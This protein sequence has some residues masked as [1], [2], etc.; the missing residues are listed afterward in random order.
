ME[1]IDPMK[2]EQL[3]PKLL[4]V[5][6]IIVNRNGGNKLKNCLKQISKQDYPKELLETLLVDGGSIDNSKE[7]AKQYGA[8][9]IKGGFP[10]NME[11]RRH[12][13][14]VK[15]ENEIIAFIDTDN[16]LPTHDWLRRMVEPLVNNKKIFAAETLHYQY[17]KKD[18][19][20][21]RYCALFGVNDPV[22]FYLGKADRMPHFYSSW[23]QSGEVKDR[24]SYLEIKFGEDLPTVGC[25]GFLIRR[26]ILIKSLTKPES[27]FHIDSIYD[28]VQQGFN[29][30]AFVKTTIT[31]DTSD[32][33]RNLVRKR[34]NYYSNH[35]LA[36]GGERRYRVYNPG[37]SS[38]NVRILLY[39]I[40]TLTLIKPLFD[41]M[42]GFVRKPDIAWFLH[43]IVCF[44]FLYAYGRVVINL[45]IKKLMAWRLR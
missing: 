42:R 33:F 45:F 4:S 5:S 8:R 24:G 15:A 26:D 39:V 31:H 27:F 3:K 14:T 32:S 38:D 34:I 43:P 10:D 20:F 21:N 2:K 1:A 6:I 19:L 40:Y 28:L 36:L 22:A 7:L 37:N 11:A 41:S 18:V 9:F 44:V 25:N 16:Y 35:G 30:I 13:G 17:N 29:R 12:V 23:H